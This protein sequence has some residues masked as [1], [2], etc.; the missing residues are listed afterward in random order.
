MKLKKIK[1]SN[2][3]YYGIKKFYYPVNG[4]K[5]DVQIWTQDSENKNKFWHA[6]NGK[7]CKTKKEV[8]QYIS[9]LGKPKRKYK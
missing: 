3:N 6:G 4:Y 2:K 9:K 8:K 7:F 5:Y 1:N